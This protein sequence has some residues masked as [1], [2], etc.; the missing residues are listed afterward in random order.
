M[1]TIRISLVLAFCSLAINA[2]DRKPEDAAKVAPD[3]TQPSDAVLAEYF[4]G[5][6]VRWKLASDF[7]ASL[8]AQQKQLQVNRASVDSEVDA[9]R[10]KMCGAD[11]QLDD[12]GSSPRCVAIPK[13]TK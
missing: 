7:E 5:L 3:V 12:T 4:H 6:A 10:K 1:K 2:D 11:T 13:P 8:T 9:I